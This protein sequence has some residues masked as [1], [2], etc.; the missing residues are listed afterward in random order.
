[1]AE[2]GRGPIQPRP[3]FHASLVSENASLLGF[4]VNRG[5]NGLDLGTRA[6]L[7]LPS[8]TLAGSHM[9]LVA[10]KK[11]VVFHSGM[12]LLRSRL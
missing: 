6:L 3:S 7:L 1:V 9:G 4:S 10:H 2:Q 5:N 11:E 12:M 8:A